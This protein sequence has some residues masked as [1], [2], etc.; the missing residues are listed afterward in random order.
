MKF[1][2]IQILSIVLLFYLITNQ[3]IPIIN[4]SENSYEGRTNLFIYEP[5]PIISSEYEGEAFLF[6]S[7]SKSFFTYLY[8]YEGDSEDYFYKEIEDENK[9]YQYKI[10]NLESQ[11]FTFKINSSRSGKLFFI[12]NSRKFIQ[13]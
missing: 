3:T 2:E 12:D 1:N 10:K 11:K 5:E 4:F 8:I 13:I 7:F 6:F 9:F